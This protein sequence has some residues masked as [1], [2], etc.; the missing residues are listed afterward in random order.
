M[1]K[2]LDNLDLWTEKSI[3]RILFVKYSTICWNPTMPIS[4]YNFHL[5]LGAMY[6]ASPRRTQTAGGKTARSIEMA[7]AADCKIYWFHI[8]TTL[9]N[10]ALQSINYSFVVKPLNY[11]CT[12]LFH[13]E[14]FF[15]LS[16]FT[17]D[18]TE[19]LFRVRYI[20]ASFCDGI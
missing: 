7:S 4:Q 13:V 9:Q 20:S 14:G 6:A 2:H 1:L 5:S 16:V 8:Y 3:Y 19:V 12:I 10:T 11:E 18:A 17:F 15:E